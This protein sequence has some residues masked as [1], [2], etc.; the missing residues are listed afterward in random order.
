[1][2]GCF[3]NPAIFHFIVQGHAF[4]SAAP[5]L[6]PLSKYCK[7]SADLLSFPFPYRRQLL[8]VKAFLH[9]IFQIPF[10]GLKKHDFR[11]MSVI[12]GVNS[13]FL[14]RHEDL[15]FLSKHGI[16]PLCHHDSFQRNV[17][18]QRAE[19]VYTD[20]APVTFGLFLLCLPCSRQSQ[21]SLAKIPS[22]DSRFANRRTG[23]FGAGGRN[24][25]VWIRCADWALEK[26]IP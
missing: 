17:G 7:H 16:T 13:L 24:G 18:K 5:C 9:N 11:I 2:A 25:I 19:P 20:P 3:C 6:F 22:D 10:S 14:I 23:C 8:R 26:V 21:T 4:A 15:I 12:I 1:M